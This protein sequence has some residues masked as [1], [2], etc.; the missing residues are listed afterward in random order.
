MWMRKPLL[1]QV[2]INVMAIRWVPIILLTTVASLVAQSRGDKTIN[3]QRSTITVHV[4]K[5]GLF[6][7]AGHEHWVNAPIASGVFN[8]SD[9]PRV[10]FQVQAAKLAV[11]PDP[12][13]EKHQAEIQQ[14]MQ[15]K[16]LESAKY[17][18]IT[19]R[20]S[21]VEKVSDGNWTIHGDLTLHGATK[22]V[23]V[24]VKKDGIIYTGSAVVKQTDFQIKPISIGGVVKVKDELEIMFRIVS[25]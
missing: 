3:V 13:D 15:E 6:S 21:G 20:S 19:F 4:G 18:E 17:P 8:D 1:R 11:K 7:A 25:Q 14:T 5:G 12:G 16:V 22:P 2:H 23:V 10:E 24:R 9:K